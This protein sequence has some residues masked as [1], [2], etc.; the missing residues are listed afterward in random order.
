MQTHVK[1]KNSVVDGS[2]SL[3]HPTVQLGAGH[4]NLRGASHAVRIFMWLA[5]SVIRS[6]AFFPCERTWQIMTFG[7]GWTRNFPRI[8]ED[9]DEGQGVDCSL[10]TL[11]FQ[12]PLWYDMV[13]NQ[14][15]FQQW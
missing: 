2:S 13:G 11:C 4:G 14:A 6:V 10:I 5:I 8:R 9:F 3:T 1:A 12:F 7:R 15:H